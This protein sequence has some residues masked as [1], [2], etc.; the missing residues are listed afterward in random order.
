M[1]PAAGA[2]NSGIAS[3]FETCTDSEKQW[4]VDNDITGHCEHGV[5]HRIL[6]E[7]CRSNRPKTA[8]FPSMK[9]RFNNLIHT[10][11]SNDCAYELCR[12][13]LIFLSTVS[14]TFR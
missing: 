14:S 9:C 8:T 4:E 11:L 2:V 5:K 10:H 1:T 7:L 13:L 3:S 6:E 12:L